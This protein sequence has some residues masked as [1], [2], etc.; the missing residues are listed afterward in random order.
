MPA[1]R[2]PRIAPPAATGALYIG[3]GDEAI[4]ARVYATSGSAQA[5]IIGAGGAMIDV[6]GFAEPPRF[7]LRFA[8]YYVAVAAQADSLKFRASTA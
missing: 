7:P 1:P 4:V 5:G 6:G 2:H 3:D 8:L